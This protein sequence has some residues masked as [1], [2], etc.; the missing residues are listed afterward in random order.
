M[1]PSVIP[2]PF[3]KWAGGKHRLL[4][5]L[6]GYI[7]KMFRNY[8]E[9]F[10]G[11]GALFFW[12]YRH[13]YLCSGVFLSDINKELIDTYIA[14]MRNPKKVMA[15]LDSY[16]YDRSF[17]YRLREKNPEELSLVERAARMI[18]LNKTCYNGLYRVNKG[19]KFNV[20]FG[21]YNNPKYY[22]YENIMA[23]SAALQNT[24]IRCASFEIV[25]DTSQPGD[26]V[27]FDPPYLP[28]SI[29]SRFSSYYKDGFSLDD[30]LR[31]RDVCIELTRRGVYVML[32]NSYTETTINLYSIE[33]FYINTVDVSRPINRMK[34]K[35][36]RIKEVVITNYPVCRQIKLP[37]FEW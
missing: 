19:G 36:G 13:N 16:P 29:T 18:Y 23:V 2:K 37:L 25:L 22:E 27:Y 30:H 8:H 24:T 28:V 5:I 3:L 21:R 6:S 20:P 17:F 15:L 4:P 35:R 11:S 33:G 9:P 10:L 1:K 14:V 7:P 26:F 32:S 12:L 31:L 34:S